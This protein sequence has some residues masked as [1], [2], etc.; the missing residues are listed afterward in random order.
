MIRELETRPAVRPFRPERYGNFTLLAPLGAGGMGEIFLAR[1]TFQGGL[2]RICVIKRILPRLARDPEFVARFHD[3]VRTLLQLRHGSIAQ[4]YDAGEFDG[5][6]WIAL[7]FVDGKDLRKLLQRLRQLGEKLPLELSLFISVKVLEALAYAHR[8]K[9]DAG[10][11]LG[12]VHRDVSPQNILLSYE[13]E[14]KVIDFGLAESKISTAKTSAQTVIGKLYYMAPEQARGDFVDRR[15]DLYAMGV[16]LWEMLVGKNPFEDVPA[17][18]LLHHI[19]QPSL[20]PIRTVDPSVPPGV[21]AVVDRALSPEPFRRFATAEE[22]R[23]RLSAC[24]SE[25]AP[26]V[27]PEALSRFLVHL[28]RAEYERE[29]EL[30]AR[31]AAREEAI[32]FDPH[33]ETEVVTVTAESPSGPHQATTE[34]I[35]GNI[36]YPWP[37]RPYLPEEYLAYARVPAPPEPP[38]RRRTWVAVAAAVPAAAL[39]GGILWKIAAPPR[40]AAASM[41]EAASRPPEPEAAPAAPPAPAP[42]PAVAEPRALE[43]PT[44]AS[45]VASPRTA[46]PETTTAPRRPSR[47]VVVPQPPKDDAEA[48]RTQ[49]LSRW[50]ALRERY[51][52]LVKVHGEERVGTIVAQMVQ[53]AQ[54]S[55][56]RSIDQPEEYDAL[57]AQLDALGEI[58]AERER[59]LR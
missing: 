39:L 58:V 37:R 14:V 40:E 46:R 3:E 59:A 21:A 19:R 32:S 48:A 31:V 4:V 51:Q 12:L 41:V 16:V 6:C 9:D 38:R 56:D 47:T 33:R 24:L 2:E 26:D 36:S 49:L 23:A 11:E 27:G 45:Q 20:P 17:D 29:R 44:V 28:F 25:M 57:E 7:E 42:Q 34:V 30:L 43:T 50:R 10:R 1:S 8:K 54:T 13:G 18:D 5:D 15:S 22:M 53:A 52:R 55:V 35:S